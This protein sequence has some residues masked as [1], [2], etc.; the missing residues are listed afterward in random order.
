MFAALVRYLA[1]SA[2][3][4]RGGGCFYLYAVSAH[5]CYLAILPRGLRPVVAYCSQAM[6]HCHLAHVPMPLVTSGLHY[7]CKLPTFSQGVSYFL[8]VVSSRLKVR[9]ARPPG[10]SGF[11]SQRAAPTRL[12]QGP[13]SLHALLFSSPFVSHSAF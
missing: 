1:V 6:P 4:A 12:R 5:L 9:L 7:H 11:C 2:L 13:L 10:N 3:P 8:Q